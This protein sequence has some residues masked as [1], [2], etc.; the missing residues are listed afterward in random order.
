M[1]PKVTIIISNYNS[2][3]WLRIAVDQIR[4][5][6]KHPY[7]I[8]ISEQTE[9]PY[10]VQAE[11]N[12]WDFITVVPVP[13]HSSGSGTDYILRYCNIDTEYIC[14][15]DVDTF[16]VS[17]EWLSLPIRLMN[18]Y[19]LT[20]VGLRAEIEAAY[21]LHY[22]H[23]GECYRIGRT[24]NFKLL[25]DAVGWTQVKGEGFRDNAVNAHSYEDAHFKNKKLSLPVTG[26]IG[27]TRSEGEYGR[28]IGNLAM[29]FCFAFTSSLHE[30][31]VKNM[32][33]EYMDWEQKIKTLPSYEVVE[34]MMAAVKYSNRLQPIQYWDGCDYAEPPKEIR[35]DVLRAIGQKGHPCFSINTIGGA[36]GVKVRGVIHV[37][38]AIGSEY[39]EYLEEGIEK[40]VFIEPIPVLFSRLIKETPPCYQCFRMIPSDKTKMVTLPPSVSGGVGTLVSM[41]RIDS[42]DTIPG[43][44]NMLF[45]DAVNY[46]RDLFDGAK[47]ILE[48]VDVICCEV[49]NEGLFFEIDDFECVAIDWDYNTFGNI[50]YLRK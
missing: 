9:N 25:S 46:R 11:Y 18:D 7:H 4:K 22:F 27:I 45:V 24:K 13:A 41:D 12:G 33:E 19:G 2:I 37:G 34:Q 38:A 5:H 28:L 30:T 8:I 29:H 39:L 3:H 16:P 47:E 35:E 1:T 15:M 32:G 50:L 21:S 43:D 44:Y 20:W 49:I 23:M 36:Y 6:T 17:D 48:S 42:I 40:V 14:S 10:D 26:R 31:P